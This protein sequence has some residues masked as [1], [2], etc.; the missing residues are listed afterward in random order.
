MSDAAK[1]YRPYVT[2]YEPTAWTDKGTPITVNGTPMVHW[3][4]A[5]VPAKGWHATKAEAQVAAAETLEAQADA[6]M[7]EAARLRKEAADAMAAS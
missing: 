4:H 7:A 2:P 3:G 6:A 1:L 5:I